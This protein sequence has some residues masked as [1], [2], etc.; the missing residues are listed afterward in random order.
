MPD[1][2]NVC[3]N[4]LRLLHK[5]LLKDPELL[6]EYNR[7][8][9]EQLS[10]GIIELV[11]QDCSQSRFHYLPHHGVIRQD[12]QTTKLRIVYNGSARSRAD[13]ASLNNC[14]ETH[15]NLIPKL[16]DII[17][18]HLATVTANIEKAFLMIGILPEDR[19]MLRF[20]WVEDPTNV[21]SDVLQSRFTRLVFGLRSSPAILGTVTSHHLDRYQSDQPELIQSIKDSFYVD[22]LI[23]EG[24]TVEEAFSIYQVAKEALAVGGFHLRKWNSNSQELRDKILPE[25]GLSNQVVSDSNQAEKIIH[26]IDC[27]NTQMADQPQDKLLCIS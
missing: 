15:P 5:R 22:N 8:I 3:L 9:R 4:R 11:P 16:F 23:C 12:K 14:L 21:E 18:W 25:L 1:H 19:D 17:R 13:G 6:Q 10:Q 2:Y 24:D 26:L 27:S 20:L 7:T